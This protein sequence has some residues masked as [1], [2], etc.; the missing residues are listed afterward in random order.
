[1]TN[2]PF[3]PS[4]AV[5]SLAQAS[6]IALSART[7]WTLPPRFDSQWWAL[8][9]PGSVAVVVAGIALDPGLAAALTYLALVAVPILAGVALSTVVKGARPVLATATVPLF[10]IAWGPFGA[11][12]GD[13]AA[14]ALSGLACIA[15]AALIVAVVPGS[16][17]RLAIYAMAV[18]DTCLV[19]ANL[20]QGP[21][22]VLNAA[23]PAAGL[24]Q[25]QFAQFGSAVLGFGDLFIAA[26]LGG[27]LADRPSLQLRAAAIAGSLALTFDL[28]FFFVAELPATVPVALTLAV[29]ELGDRRRSSAAG[30]GPR[31][32]GHSASEPFHLSADQ[33]ELSATATCS[34]LM[35]PEPAFQ[36]T[37]GGTLSALLASRGSHWQTAQAWR[38]AEPANS[39]ARACGSGSSRMS[40]QS[41]MNSP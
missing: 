8:V 29:L 11:I 24:P 15:L 40:S 10:V 38:K 31:A 21:N 6:L 9:L 22:D 17:L 23:A 13:I 1:M 16:W 5:L 36:W 4:I 34:R 25:L 41:R 7:R 32:I 27:M 12:P 26:V 30:R 39:K 35:E 2:L 37:G 14:L 3:A 20:L 18:V 28:L 19:G 33:S